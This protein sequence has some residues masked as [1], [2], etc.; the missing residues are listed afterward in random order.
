MCSVPVRVS[1]STT[2]VLSWFGYANVSPFG[3][4]LTNVA[5]HTP[6]LLTTSR[7]TDECPESVQRSIDPRAYPI[8]EE[9]I[10]FVA[11]E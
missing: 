1:R 10:G 2:F 7:V 6:G 3:D 4:S 11:K 9:P 5:H 8:G